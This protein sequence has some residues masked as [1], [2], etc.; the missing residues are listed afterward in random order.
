[1]KKLQFIALALFTS[2][3]FSSCSDDEHDHGTNEEELITT[4]I[5]TL[6]SGN[7]T[8]TLTSKDLDGNGPN[9]PV[10]TTSG[11]LTVN[12]NYTGSIQFLN[13]SVSP[14]I[15]IT[16]EIKE[17]G[18]EHQIFYQAAASIGAFTYADADTKG[19]PIGLAFTLRTAA[20]PTTGT[21]TVVLK[22]EPNKSA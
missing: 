20:S 11:D 19:K 5:T 14:S 1:M 12:T 17:E 6:T 2:T 16:K 8:I 18:L 21:I 22:H 13:E 9:A 15:D 3:L 10:V 7:Q 4:V